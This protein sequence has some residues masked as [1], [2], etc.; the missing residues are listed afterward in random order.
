LVACAALAFGATAWRAQGFLAQSLNPGLEG[1]DLTV[2]GVVAAMPQRN[3]TGVRFRFDVDSAPW[4]AQAVH[5]PR[6]I[7]LAWYSGVYAR[8]EGPGEMVGELQR[9]VPLLQAG[10]RWQFTVRLKAPHG[11]VNPHGFDYE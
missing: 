1:H 9:V 7:E 5:L 2:T 4:Q 8:G 10:Q 11:A 3:D 6:R